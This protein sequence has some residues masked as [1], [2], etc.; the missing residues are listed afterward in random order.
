M[1]YR[2]S[3]TALG[4]G[5]QFRLP[6]PPA[7]EQ[8]RA[9][10]EE[11]WKRPWAIGKEQA[12]GEG[13]ATQSMNALLLDPHRDPYDM[14][15]EEKLD[16]LRQENMNKTDGATEPASMGQ[17]EATQGTVEVRGWMQEKAKMYS[18]PPA[19]MP[20]AQKWR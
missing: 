2:T 5:V 1:W 15:T 8:D 19:N 10:L 13:P 6:A 14:T 11:R 12:E 17:K 7:S 3:K 9:A 20:A 16:A 4:G 18:T